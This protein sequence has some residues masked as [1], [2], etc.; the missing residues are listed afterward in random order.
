M[1]ALKPAKDMT[2]ALQSVKQAMQMYEEIPYF[3]HL[4][5]LLTNGMALFLPTSYLRETMVDSIKYVNLIY[6]DHKCTK[7]APWMI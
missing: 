2:E 1:I 6:S 7:N 4:N 5:I 3:P